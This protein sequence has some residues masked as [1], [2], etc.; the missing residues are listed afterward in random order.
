MI[1]SSKGGRRSFKRNES[2]VGEKGFIL[3]L[4]I[5]HDISV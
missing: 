5:L 3:L 2:L 4:Y 1:P